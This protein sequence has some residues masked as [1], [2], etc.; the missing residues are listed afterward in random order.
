MQKLDPDLVSFLQEQGCVVV[1]TIDSRGNIHNSCKGIVNIHPEGK[2]YLLD[3]YMRS[4][5]SNLKKDAHI[6]ITAVDEHAFLGYCLKGK[7][8]I[9]KREELSPEDIKAWEDR[10]A[11][12]LTRRI[13]KNLHEE[14]GG[15]SHPEAS[16][17]RPEYM[18]AMEVEEIVDLTP[19]HIKRGA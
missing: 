12:R 16:L 1:S 19:G 15:G 11:G 17:P 4:T 14:K 7:G 6:S 10:I 3:L 8:R 5:L 9:I 18:I 13:I 2:V